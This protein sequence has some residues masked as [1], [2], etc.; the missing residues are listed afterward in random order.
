MIALIS[1]GGKSSL[2]VLSPPPGYGCANRGA[3]LDRRAVED[4]L[5]SAD[6]RERTLAVRHRQVAPFRV[7]RA[8]L[9]HRKAD[10]AD[11][12]GGLTC[13]GTGRAGPGRA[14]GRG[15]P[16]PPRRPTGRPSPPMR[17]HTT[18]AW[19][20]FADLLARPAARPAPA[21]AASRPGRRASRSAPPRRQL[22]ERRDL[23]V[24][25]HRHRHGPRDRRRGHHEQV[26]RPVGLGAQRVPL[27]D[28][29]PVLLV[30]D[31]QPEV[32]ELHLAP[33]AG[34]ACRSRCRPR[35]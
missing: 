12:D 3:L 4:P 1:S 6:D 29:E 2:P 26:R 22:A 20:P 25:E 32:G 35:R 27:L 19:W 23:E 11:A 13:A 16:P 14:G 31:D 28:A 9:G 21:T 30:D 18:Y 7:A 34:R 10:H 5:R 8:V 33:G 17:G 15:R 24:A